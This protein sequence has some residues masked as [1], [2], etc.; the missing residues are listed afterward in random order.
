[1]LAHLD[2][3]QLSRLKSVAVAGSDNRA[4]AGIDVTVIIP[5]YNDVKHLRVALSSI[6]AAL[7]TL[8]WE[9]IVADDQSTDGTSRLMCRRGNSQIRYIQMPTHTGA[10]GAPRNA[11]LAQAR[12]NWVTMLDSDDVLVPGGIAE[13]VAAAGEAQMVLGRTRR[14]FMLSGKTSPWMRMHYA[15]DRR[16]QSIFEAPDLVGDTNSTATIYRRDLVAELRYREAVRYEDLDF[17]TRALVLAEGIAVVAKDVYEWRV[18]PPKWRTSITQQREDASSLRAR[19]VAIDEIQQFLDTQPHRVREVVGDQVMRKFLRHDA[20]VYLGDAMSIDDELLSEYVEILAPEIARATPA[21]TSQV[22]AMKQATL[23][24]VR[25]RDLDGIR[26]AS[27]YDRALGALGGRVMP[28][29]QT[30]YSGVTWAADDGSEVDLGN[31]PILRAPWATVPLL[32]WLQDTEYLGA[33]RTRISGVSWDALDKFGTAPRAMLVM[34]RYERGEAFAAPVTMRQI[35]PQKWE[36]AAEFEMPSQLSLTRPNRW[37]AWIVV[38]GPNGANA[39]RV[40][41]RGKGDPKTGVAAAGR[42][43]ILG[44]RYGWYTAG[45]GVLALKK[46]LKHKRGTVFNAL[47]VGAAATGQWCAQLFGNKTKPITWL[48]DDMKWLGDASS[49]EAAAQLLAILPQGVSAKAGAPSGV[50]VLKPQAGSPAQFDVA[51][52]KAANAGYLIVDRRHLAKSDPA[53][54]PAIKRIDAP[55]IWEVGAEGL[56]MPEA[57]ALARQIG[58]EV[59]DQWPAA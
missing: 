16:V 55:W 34:R 19:M 27:Q 7:G 5:T 40:R 17:T 15:A 58:A 21:Q 4:G 31:W 11:A 1:M 13:L 44:R 46:V 30:A 22:S 28:G 43:T 2:K 54:G 56:L 59:V 45:F 9:A 8:K 25:A 37:D 49:A 36:F 14:K 33:A 48:S 39:S 51:S 38:A 18:Y 32:H 24:M 10:A 42:D 26:L 12:G 47:A 35:A 3:P 23:D 29:E 57:N 6:P 53:Y 50:T 41:A 52:W 20:F